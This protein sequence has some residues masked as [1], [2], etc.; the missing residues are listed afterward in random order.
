MRRTLIRILIAGQPFAVRD[1]RGARDVRVLTMNIF[2][3]HR[4]WDD[5]RRVLAGGLVEI[6]PDVVTFQEAIT[7]DGLG[8]RPLRGCG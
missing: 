2:A 6:N 8:Q 4:S 5:R 1:L 7:T 3:H